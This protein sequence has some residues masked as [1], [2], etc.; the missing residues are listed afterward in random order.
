MSLIELLSIVELLNPFVSYTLDNR[1]ILISGTTRVIPDGKFELD[2]QGQHLTCFLGGVLGMS[3]RI[4]QRPEDLITAKKLVNGCAWAYEI[5]PNG[6][7]PELFKAWPCPN[8][9]KCTWDEE[10]YHKGVIFHNSPVGSDIPKKVDSTLAKAIIMKGNLPI[11]FTDVLDP[12][13]ILR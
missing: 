2:P 10:E 3:S 11:G 1:D 8:S 12:R 9:Q 5:S 6:I 13:Y 4:F 7:M